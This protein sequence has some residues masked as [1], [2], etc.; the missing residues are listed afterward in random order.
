MS[1]LTSFDGR[2]QNRGRKLAYAAFVLGGACLLAAGC[3]GNVAAGNAAPSSAP[4]PTFA[5]QAGVP[6]DC[7]FGP[8]L[9]NESGFAI[10]IEVPQ[11]TH[12]KVE[13]NFGDGSAPAGEDPYFSGDNFPHSYQD[14]GEYTVTA[15]MQLPGRQT[16]S[17]GREVIKFARGSNP[18]SEVFQ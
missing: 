1:E 13:V 15:T 7:S 16:V 8:L 11:H 18:Y 4:S 6:Q 12:P 14:P 10:E 3:G 9:T 5:T 2:T 17:C